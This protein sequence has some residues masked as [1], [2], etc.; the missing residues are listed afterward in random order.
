MFAPGRPRGV[1]LFDEQGMPFSESFGGDQ[2]TEG[3]VGPRKESMGTTIRMLLATNSARE[4]EEGQDPLDNSPRLDT[5]TTGLTP[6]SSNSPFGVL[7]LA[8]DA[9]TQTRHVFERLRRSTI[10]PS[11]T[12]PPKVLVVEDD[13][14]YR[15][16]SRKFLEKFGCEIETVEDAKQALEK[17]NERKFDLVLMDIFLGPHMDG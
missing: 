3:G 12:T 7:E 6:S 2:W 1:S 10:I 14:V 11:W 9:P 16:L 13:L 8:E 17:M 4:Q 15:Q 5:I